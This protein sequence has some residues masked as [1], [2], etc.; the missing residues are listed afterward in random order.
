[1]NPEELTRAGIS[2]WYAIA[3]AHDKALFYLSVAGIAV[4]NWFRSELT[5]DTTRFLYVVAS[6]GFLLVIL[7]MSGIFNQNRLVIEQKLA[8]QQPDSRLLTALDFIAVL[9]F[10]IGWI[11]AVALSLTL[12]S[13]K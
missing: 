9:A 13:G 4:L 5:T 11:C 2:A 6:I 10:N 3:L 12:L 7:A 8:G 1:M